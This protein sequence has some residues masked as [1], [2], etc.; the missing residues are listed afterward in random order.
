MASLAVAMVLSLYLGMAA[1]NSAIQ[2]SLCQV[3]AGFMSSGASLLS[4]HLRPLRMVDGW[5]QTSALE[6]DSWPPLAYDV[7]MPG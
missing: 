6:A 5:V 1:T 3:G 7:S 4:I 2:L